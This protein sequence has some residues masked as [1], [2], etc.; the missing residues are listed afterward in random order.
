VIEQ[1]SESVCSFV[2]GAPLSVKRETHFMKGEFIDLTTINGQPLRAYRALPPSGR[3]P[4]VLVLQEIFGVNVAMR[5]VADA[6]AE[7][8]FVAVVP[9]LFWRLQ[10]G[11]ELGYDEDDSRKAVALWQRF[12]LAQGVDDLVKAVQAVRECDVVQGGVGL[13]GFCLGGQLT[14]KVAAKVKV[15]AAVC[16]YGVRLGD[17]LDE[18]AA[19]DVPTLFHFGEADPHVPADVREA[20]SSVA[21]TRPNMRVNVYPDAVHGFF[22]AFRESSFHAEAHRQAWEQSLDLLREALAGSAQVSVTG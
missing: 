2:R 4:A 11:V 3:G 16:F 1:R 7:Q 17:S 22:N 14:V 12:D 9:D 13:L 10:S 20:V 5:S 15:D 21:Q 19:I 18:I 6:L 8:G